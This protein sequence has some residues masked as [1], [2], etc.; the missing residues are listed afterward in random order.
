MDIDIAAT[1]EPIAEMDRL[2]NE[3]AELSARALT[4]SRGASGWISVPRGSAFVWRARSDH[5]RC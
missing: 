4:G 1:P 3:I 5:C 2:G